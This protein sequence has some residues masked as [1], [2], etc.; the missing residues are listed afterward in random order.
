MNHPHP[1]SSPVWEPVEEP[2]APA[3]SPALDAMLLLLERESEW[4]EG[5]SHRLFLRARAHP[6]LPQAVMQQTHRAEFERL[7]T[8]GFKPVLREEGLFDACLYLGT[9]QREENLANFARGLLALRPDGLFLCAMPNNLGASRYEK[10]L[11]QLAPLVVQFSKYHSRVFG[12]RLGPEVDRQLLLEQAARGE[13]R[14]SEKTGFFTCPGIFGWDKIDEGSALLA[15]N[16]PEDLSGSGADLG[17]GYGYLA[18]QI[19]LSNKQVDR[20][21]LFEVEELALQA[22]RKNL[23]DLES[24]AAV[25]YHWH[26]VTT[27]IPP[28][29][30]DWVVMNPPFHQGHKRSLELGQRFVRLAAKGL[31]RDGVLYMVGNRHLPY[32]AI[33]GKF[34]GKV[35]TLAATSRF[36][37]LAA[38]R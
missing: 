9:S 30:Y 35:R 1:G 6:D 12:V 10:N 13:L 28:G 31:R 32:E 29:Q 11:R 14:R 26:D 25:G 15:R 34:L 8:S 19:L 2:L 20:L 24:S 5:H 23:Q 21:D 37:V 36:K 3:P 38:W 4:L 16:L 17:A 33:L 27:G 18:H 22:A 7:L